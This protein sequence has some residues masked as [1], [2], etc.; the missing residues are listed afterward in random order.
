VENTTGQ[1]FLVSEQRA[2]M[3]NKA[4]TL[5]EI[6]IVVV[7]LGILAAIVIP[8]MASCTGY[9]KDS[10]LAQD[11]TMFKRMVLVYKAQHLETSPGYPDGDKTQTP[12]EEAM[13][14]QVTS[15]SN[16]SGQT[17][18]VNSAEYKY[19][20][21]MEKLPQNPFNG[22]RTVYVLGNS[23]D[24]PASAD[25]SYGWAY[26]PATQEVRPYNSGTD[27]TGKRYYDY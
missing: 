17:A 15:A 26:K 6:L 9:A 4:F 21:Y 24:F 16:I 5:V 1:P 13:L 8:A 11:L 22:L 23:E 27:Q 18:L 10:A 7:I 12:T 19:G 2:D 20:P 3:N 25:D 14:A